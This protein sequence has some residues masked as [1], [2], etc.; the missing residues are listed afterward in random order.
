M[1]PTIHGLPVLSRKAA[2]A[3]GKHSITIGIDARLERDIL[4]SVCRDHNPTDAVLIRRRDDKYE[5]AVTRS[6]P[7]GKLARA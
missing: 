1:T 6:S 7:C 5:L 4:A 2:A 3:L